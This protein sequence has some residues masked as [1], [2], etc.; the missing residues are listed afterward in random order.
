MAKAKRDLPQAR[1]RYD[2]DF[3]AWTREQAAVLRREAARG[4]A[5]DLDLENL[6]EEIESL[7]KRD[8]RALTSQIARITERLL[9]LQHSQSRTG[10]KR[11]GFLADRP[12]LKGE[13][14]TMLSESYE[15]GRRF[16]V[17][18]LRN[19]LDPA[20]LPETCPYTSTSFSTTTGGRA[21]SEW[22]F[23]AVQQAACALS[24]PSDISISRNRVTSP[25]RWW[26]KS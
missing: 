4:A 13:L 20:T 26:G 17:R 10:R 8:R 14:K 16:A 12:G 11:A 18:S 22:L 23:A 6:A 2:R 3:F 15:D 9:K 1:S 25:C 5:S 7:G 19:D 24:A 21:A